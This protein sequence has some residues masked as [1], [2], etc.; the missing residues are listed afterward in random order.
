[1]KDSFGHGFNVGMIYRNKEFEIWFPY[2]FNRITYVSE[3]F[4]KQHE[5]FFYDPICI[6]EDVLS[7]IYMV[8]FE[9]A[10]GEGPDKSVIAD[11]ICD[12]DGGLRLELLERLQVA[13]KFYDPNAELRILGFEAFGGRPVSLPVD[14][15]E[16]AQAARDVIAAACEDGGNQA[17]P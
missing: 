4:G 10:H 13:R 15:V 12:L 17:G 11:F 3:S 9:R 5:G 6:P 2:Y 14:W 8:K 16:V 7:H 1:M